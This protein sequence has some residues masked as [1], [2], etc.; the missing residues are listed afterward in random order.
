MRPALSP[1][2]RQYLDDAEAA[3]A[4]YSTETEFATTLE[5]HPDLV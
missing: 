1:K 4:S 5:H 2:T 3:L